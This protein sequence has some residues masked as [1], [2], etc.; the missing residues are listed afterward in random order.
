MKWIF[1]LLLT[2]AFYTGKANSIGNEIWNTTFT[3]C[4]Q[5]TMNVRAIDPT[6]TYNG[7]QYSPIKRPTIGFDGH[8]L[9]LYGQFRGLTLLL[10]D[11]GGVAYATSVAANANQVELPY[12]MT[13][14][15]EL[16]MD[17]GTY[18]YTCEIEM[19]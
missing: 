15:Y 8:T 1:T 16:Q 9:Y 17:D 18:L 3:N 19:E 13:G 10:V 11:E 5:L 12:G 4:I 7:H 2:L 14:T 6:G